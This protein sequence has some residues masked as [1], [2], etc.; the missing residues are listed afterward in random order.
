MVVLDEG[1]L[2]LPSS[3]VDFSPAGARLKLPKNVDLPRKFYV[4]FDHRIAPCRL[5]WHDSLT[6]GIAYRG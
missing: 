1:L 6:A 3:I 5:V 2:R 4:L